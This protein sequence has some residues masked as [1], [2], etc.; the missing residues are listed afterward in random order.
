MVTDKHKIYKSL[1]ILD[2]SPWLTFIFGQYFKR[3]ASFVILFDL[4]WSF[5][6]PC[7]GGVASSICIDWT[8]EKKAFFRSILLL[9][10][11]FR[12]ANDCAFLILCKHARVALQFIPISLIKKRLNMIRMSVVV[13]SCTFA[14]IMAI[15]PFKT[16]PVKKTEFSLRTFVA[17]D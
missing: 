1:K 14:I 4:Q 12:S 8:L 13:A 11:E 9:T 2:K 16:G 5:V 6:V 3:R 15:F 7:R 10:F 17:F